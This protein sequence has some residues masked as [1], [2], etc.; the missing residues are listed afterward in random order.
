MAT[1]YLHIGSFKTGSTFIQSC[2]RNSRERLSEL[3]LVYPMGSEGGDLGPYS[4]SWG[5]GNRLFDSREQF[6]EKI[7]GS[8]KP[9]TRGIVFSNEDLCFTLRSPSLQQTLFQTADLFGFERI[10]ILFF[11]RNPIGFT[12]SNWG[13]NVKNALPQDLEEFIQNHGQQTAGH[14]QGS[15]GLLSSLSQSQMVELTTLNYSVCS[16]DLVDKLSQWLGVPRETWTIPGKDPVNRSLSKS[17]TR[18]HLAFNRVMGQDA[19]LLAKALTERLPYVEPY[20]PVPS[21]ESQEKIW[22][23]CKPWLEQ[24]NRFL[25]P[26]HEITFDRLEPSQTAEDELTDDQ[27]KVIAET[28]GGMIMT[29]N[30]E[31]TRLN[32]EVTRLNGEVVRL[33]GEVVRLNGEVTRLNGQNRGLETELK[34]IYDAETPIMHFLRRMASRYRNQG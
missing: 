6:Q 8:L 12:V 22:E 34:R 18:I 7:R 26:G 24:L 29:L 14:L 17:E 5:N 3:G 32:Q 23:Q 9:E 20:K 19:M 21:I 11:L 1:L 28:M 25:A 16:R 30:E 13:N 27:I 2:L 4:L 15:V 10:K 33:N 31:S